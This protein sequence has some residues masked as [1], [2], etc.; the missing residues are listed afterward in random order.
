MKK[1]RHGQLVKNWNVGQMVDRLRLGNFSWSREYALSLRMKI[2][3]PFFGAR[4]CVHIVMTFRCD[5]ATEIGV[6]RLASVRC[7]TGLA[8]D[9]ERQTCDWKTHVKNC[10]QL[11]SKKLSIFFLDTQRVPF[12]IPGVQGPAWSKSRAPADWPLIWTNRPATGRARSPI[13]TNL[14][15]SDAKRG[16]PKPAQSFLYP[17][18]QT[19]K[20]QS[21]YYFVFFQFQE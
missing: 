13:V 16:T 14:R 19:K 20:I 11:E 2:D 7:P 4:V 12:S 6:T 18:I 5:K 10:D 15:V 17:Q 1:K 21:D 9:I 8:F 3:K